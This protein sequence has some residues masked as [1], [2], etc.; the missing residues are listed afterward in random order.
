MID[1]YITP[2]VELLP[3]D[4]VLTASPNEEWGDNE[5]PGDGGDDW[6]PAP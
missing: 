6:R 4:D 1:E 2:I 5:L 3:L